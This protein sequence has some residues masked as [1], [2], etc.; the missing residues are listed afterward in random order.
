MAQ[1][2]GMNPGGGRGRIELVTLTDP[3]EGAFTV[4]LP[5]GW[6]NQAHSVRPYGQHRA[7]VNSRSPD[8]GTYLFFGDPQIPSFAVPTPMLYPGHPMANLNPLSQVHPYVPAEPFFVQYLG[9]RHGQAPGFRITASAP[10]PALEQDAQAEAQRR[11]VQAWSTAV[12]LSFEFTDAG[13]RV[14]GRLHGM[15]LA[16][17]QV[18]VADVFGAMTTED[19]DPARWDDLLFGIARSRQT[20]PRWRQR[21]D[22]AHTDRMGEIQQDHQAAMSRLHASHQQ[23]MAQIQSSAQAHQARMDALHAAGDAQVQG[24]YAAQASI[25]G[26]HRGFMDALGERRQAG[27]GAGPGPGGEGDD[28]HRRFLNYINNENTVID[29]SGEAHQV[30]AGH[31]RYYRHR[32]DGTFVGTDSTVEREDLRARLGVNPDDYEEVRVKR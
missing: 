14:R 22:Q 20:D 17:G 9:Q 26:T 16:M 18:W 3:A 8:G 30:E 10:C 6:Q 31:D 13:R 11:G 28:G 15:T 24:W 7:V 5:R 19:M 29:A 4:R 21:Q 27:P 23:N 1:D 12:S 32:R 2:D 25:D